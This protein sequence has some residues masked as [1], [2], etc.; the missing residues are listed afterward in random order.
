LVIS[1][2]LRDLFSLQNIR[3]ALWPIQPSI[4]L[5]PGESFTLGKANHSLQ[6]SG[7][8]QNVLS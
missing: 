6:N 5:G 4:Q 1:K 8:V 7:K 2:G 3:Q